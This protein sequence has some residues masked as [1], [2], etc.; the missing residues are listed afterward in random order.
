M[1][2][3]CMCPILNVEYFRGHAGRFVCIS[4]GADW[5][6]LDWPA[7][8]FPCV[9]SCHLVCRHR[10]YEIHTRDAAIRMEG[11]P[12]K[13]KSD[14]AAKYWN[15]LMPETCGRLLDYA[16]DNDAEKKLELPLAFNGSRSAFVCST[17]VAALSAWLC[18]TVVSS[19]D[20]ISCTILHSAWLRPMVLFL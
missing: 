5:A 17:M 3:L 10:L 14:R 16:A 7:L 11:V 13:F 8:A 9:C 12:L 15:N 6:M 20:A 4:V 1:N 18:P 2:Y 19:L